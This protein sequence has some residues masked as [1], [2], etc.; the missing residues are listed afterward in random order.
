MSSNR[1][2]NPH[3]PIA[4][5]PMMVSDRHSLLLGDAVGVAAEAPSVEP[6]QKRGIFSEF[7]F[8]R[9]SKKIKTKMISKYSLLPEIHK[10]KYSVTLPVSQTFQRDTQKQAAA[11]TNPKFNSPFENLSDKVKDKKEYTDASL[12]INYR[13]ALEPKVARPFLN[14]ADQTPRKIELER[15]KRLYSS[16]EVSKLVETELDKLKQMGHLPKY[17]SHV[18]AKKTVLG[19]GIAEVG[20][21]VELED[22]GI[23]KQHIDQDEAYDVSQ[24]LPLEAFDDT[25]YDV[26]TVDDWLD[27]TAFSDEFNENS[28]PLENKVPAK[29]NRNQKR[30]I[31]KP[32]Y[33][34][35][36]FAV[37]PLPAK[38]FDGF[39]WRDCIVIAYDDTCNLWKVKWRSYNGWE[40]DKKSDLSDEFIHPEDEN[41]KED[42]EVQSTDP[43]LII[44]GKEIWTHR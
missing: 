16:L 7:L 14:R 3:L 25:E 5:E 28:I 22:H 39:E 38:A 27:M 30:G 41:L 13:K 21:G 42:F 11:K 19:A 18:K 43:R 2:K 36:R 34:D 8:E 15:K 31:I 24:L 20:G 32:S 17:I 26:R 9:E 37:V 1:G 10:P 44:D 4:L 12:I 23:E 29:S 40:L 6:N 33:P 35:I